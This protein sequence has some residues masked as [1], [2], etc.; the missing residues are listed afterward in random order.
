MLR[1]SGRDSSEENTHCAWLLSFLPH[2]P[3]TSDLASSPGFKS[4][5]TELG[6]T[7]ASAAVISTSDF[8]CTSSSHPTAAVTGQNVSVL[9]RGLICRPH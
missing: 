9:T 6:S 2:S 1:E 5:G 7:S 3:H 8:P 4:A